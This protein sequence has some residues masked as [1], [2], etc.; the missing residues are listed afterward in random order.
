MSAWDKLYSEKVSSLR[1]SPIREMLH[2]TRQPGMISF[3][4]GNPDPESFPVDLF[5]ESAS[6]LKE[7]GKMCFNMEP[8]RATHPSKISFALGLLPGWADRSRKT[9]S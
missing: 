1:P 5:Y 7:Q 3:A 8:R 2:A 6:I 9:S 4:G